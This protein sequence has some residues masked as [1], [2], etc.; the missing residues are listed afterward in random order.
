MTVA[1]SCMYTRPAFVAPAKSWLSTPTRI[2]FF[3][4][5]L[6]SGTVARRSAQC[7]VACRVGDST[8]V[9]LVV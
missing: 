8:R 2:S 7:I 1:P 6:R 5:S 4:S 3:P 9:K